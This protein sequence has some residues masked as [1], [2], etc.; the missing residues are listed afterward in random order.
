MASKVGVWNQALQRLGTRRVETDTEST[1]E[2]EALE[3]VWDETRLYVLEQYP[4]S[5]ARTVDQLAR[6]VATPGTVWKYWYKLPADTV[7]ILRV[8]DDTDN[9][10]W[11]TGDSIPYERQYDDRIA[12]DA[13][14]V[15]L[16]YLRDVEDMNLW[17]SSARSALA[18]RLAYE[19]AYRLTESTAKADRAE[20][21]YFE[22]LGQ[23]KSQD[24]QRSRGR[25]IN[26][27][28]WVTSRIAS[29]G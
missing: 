18:W 26:Q 28:S 16:Y 1:A 22:E 8:S 11:Q 24:S 25:R 15:Y 17:V 5:F 6:L 3:A 9:Y 27:T 12:A 23:A 13:E 19:V 7:G 21:K 29:V 20:K 4:W 14:A 2:A 10:E